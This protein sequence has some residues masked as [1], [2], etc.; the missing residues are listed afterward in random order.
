MSEVRRSQ[1]WLPSLAAGLIIGAVEAVLAIA[2]AAFVFGGLLVGR[3][4]DGIGLYL[5]A[6]VLTL[7]IL[8]WRAGSRGV[9]GSVQ[10]AAVAV[11]GVVATTTAARVA[12]LAAETTTGDAFEAPDVFLTVIAA[13]LVVTVL[14]GVVFFALGRFK[15]GN[16]VRFVPYP[17]VGGFL[18]GTGWLLLKGGIYV[19][20]GVLLPLMT[21]KS[22]PRTYLRTI[23]TLMHSFV[24]Q[25]WLPA[26]AFGVILLVAVR[27]IKRPLVIPA[28]LGIGLLLFAI[29]MLVTGSS[30]ESAREG[31]WL[32]GPLESARWQPWTLR[33][34]SGADWSAV[35]G[36]WGGIA[37]AVFVAVIAIL[38]NVSG[39]EVVLHRDL[40]TNRELRDAGF[41]NVISG[42][43]G[44]IPGYHAL[45]LTALAER[46]SVNARVAGLIG[47]TVPLAAV[48]FGAAVIEL[49]PRMIVGG[50]LVFLGLA[51][52]V[53][54]VWDKRK[55]LPPLEY[56]V[57][58]VILAAVIARGFLPGVVLGLVLAVVLFVVNY[59]RIELVREVAFGETY[60]S[61]VD[62][63]PAERAVLRTRGDLVQILRVNGFVFFGSANGLLER[64][65]KRVEAAPLRFLVI[66]LR[67]VTGVDSSGVVA[68]VKVMHRAE[69]YGFEL[70]FTGA[71]DQVRKQLRL[72]GVVASEGI[73]RFEP[74]LDR[75][76]QRVEEGLLEGAA[77][78][79]L[80]VADGSSD[81]L[82]GMPPG[83]R[84]YLERREL[85]VGTVLIR[86][87]E[88]PDDVFVLESGRLSVETVTP[89]GTRMRLR[90]LRPGVVVGE[91]AMYTGVPRSA[92]VVAETPSVVLRLSRESIERVEAADPALAAALHRWLATTLSER[93]GES[94]RAFDA[95]FD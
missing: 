13:T 30:I 49:I 4:G 39:T 34:L 14:C 57:V 22:W 72:G 54:W 63:P 29:G 82:A 87:D 18:A 74:D 80:V 76:L 65:R 51:F 91:M 16:L 53:E 21:G 79:P 85:P 8:A 23:E 48:V 88:Q 81:G 69:A 56:G 2:F 19:A 33:A 31:R 20:S 58:L 11:L 64:I 62:R 6:A 28:V 24:L 36:Q 67:R 7:G 10:D 77:A 66:D 92:D 9:V 55:A 52:L 71:S 70:V 25:L 50:V 95:L 90:T 12:L 40:D 75:G 1:G 45:S 37:T 83:L 42:A 17:V 3:L 60:H 38:F 44:G 93:L 32:L 78:E 46:M 94:L 15:L 73:V 84:T 59:G 41:L 89:E 47:A 43:L 61:N 86:Q 26:F 35:L 68:F 5:V 27:L